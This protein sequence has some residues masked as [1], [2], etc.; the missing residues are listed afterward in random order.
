MNLFG[1]VVESSKRLDEGREYLVPGS[2][3]CTD[4]AEKEVVPPWFILDEALKCLPGRV[5]ERR[6]A[7]VPDAAVHMY[8]LKRLTKGRRG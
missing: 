8:L 3:N 7:F 1:V 5:F 2:A 6:C 4:K